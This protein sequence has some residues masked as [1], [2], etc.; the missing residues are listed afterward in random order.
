MFNDLENILPHNLTYQSR[1]DLSNDPVILHDNIIIKFSVIIGLPNH[2]P[3]DTNN[4]V[5]FSGSELA[6]YD[7]EEL[8]V[9]L[10]AFVHDDIAAFEIDEFDVVDDFFDLL[11]SQ[12]VE[13]FGVM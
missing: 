10:G 1:A 12:D 2:H 6:F 9:L 7:N 5:G 4:G 11:G 8:L 3:L 13:V